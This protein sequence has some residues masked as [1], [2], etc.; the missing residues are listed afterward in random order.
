[1]ASSNNSSFCFEM[2]LTDFFS[3]Y[4]FRLTSKVRNPSCSNPNRIRSR[5]SSWGRWLRSIIDF[6]TSMHRIVAMVQSLSPQAEWS[7]ST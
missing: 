2:P 1:M 3:R 5:D 7:S 6:Q 4:C